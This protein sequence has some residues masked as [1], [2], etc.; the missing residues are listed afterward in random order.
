VE[1]KKAFL[2]LC[3]AIFTLCLV[4]KAES[5][6]DGLREYPDGS[7]GVDLGGGYE[8]IPGEERGGPDQLILPAGYRQEYQDT[9]YGPTTNTG[10]AIFPD[11]EFPKSKAMLDL[12]RKKKEEED[13][14]KE[15]LFHEEQEE[16]KPKSAIWGVY[17]P[18]EEKLPQD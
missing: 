1:R 12:E 3:T 7:Y 14:M 8:L 10:F 2:V 15:Y 17:I 11:F 5:N 9:R 6:D 13:K 16:E 18:G 4:V